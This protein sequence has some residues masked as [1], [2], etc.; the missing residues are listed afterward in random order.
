[1]KLIQLPQTAKPFLHWAHGWTVRCFKCQALLELE[2]TDLLQQLGV[3][4]DKDTDE[5][6][7]FCIHC[8]TAFSVHRNMPISEPGTPITDHSNMTVDVHPT[9]NPVPAGG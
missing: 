5:A 2:H 6:R 9:T 4:A 3:R 7:A 8:G 1:M